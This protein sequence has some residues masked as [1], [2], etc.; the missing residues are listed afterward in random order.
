MTTIRL[1]SPAGALDSRAYR[2]NVISQKYTKGSDSPDQGVLSPISQFSVKAL[3]GDF[4][5]DLL[6][7]E[8]RLEDLAH[9]VFLSTPEGDGPEESDRATAYLALV[10]AATY[11]QEARESLEKVSRGA[12]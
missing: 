10:A 1:L 3:R 12:Q 11:V 4:M 7:T 6:I 9:E 5:P 2:A 8:Q